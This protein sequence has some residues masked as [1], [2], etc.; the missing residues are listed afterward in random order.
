M[1]PKLKDPEP[2][3]V[4]KLRR[5]LM[6][7]RL[8]VQMHGKTLKVEQYQLAIAY[9]VP[10]AEAERSAPKRTVEVGIKEFRHELRGCWE[11][12]AIGKDGV[13]CIWLTYHGNRVMAVLSVKQ[14]KRYK[15]TLLT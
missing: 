9:I 4:S 14:Y 13:D 2:I 5:T 1:I 3:K 7:Q 15:K 8:N 6:A 12:L 11:L 10:V